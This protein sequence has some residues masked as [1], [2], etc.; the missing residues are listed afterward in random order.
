MYNAKIISDIMVEWMKE[1]D[2]YEGDKRH[3]IFFFIKA[4]G[5]SDIYIV[6]HD[7]GKLIGENGYLANKYTAKF[8]NAFH[9]PVLRVKIDRPDIMIA[10]GYENDSAIFYYNQNT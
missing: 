6:S 1:A 2:C 7:T 10:S 5:D 3:P 4:R 8:R 9:N